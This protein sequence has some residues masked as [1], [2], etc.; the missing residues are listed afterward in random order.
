M[1]IDISTPLEAPADLVWELLHK[2]QSLRYVAKPLLC[3]MGDLPERWPALVGL[4]A[5]KECC[6]SASYR[7]RATS[8]GWSAS[9]KT[10]ASYFQM[11]TV[12]Q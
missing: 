3:F 5:L 6:S 8:F 2:T 10:S 7:P 12:E 1:R 11:S 4:C 9:M